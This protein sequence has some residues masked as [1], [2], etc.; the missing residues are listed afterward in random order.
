MAWYEPISQSYQESVVPNSSPVTSRKTTV[1]S[2]LRVAHLHGLGHGEGGG[3]GAGVVLG[4]AEV[5]VVVRANDD[6]LPRAL[7]PARDHADHVEAEPAVALQAHVDVGLDGRRDGAGLAGG[8]QLGA[9]RARDVHGGRRA[10]VRLGVE[11]AQRVRQAEVLTGGVE[12][13][14]RVRED[15]G[16]ARRGTRPASAGS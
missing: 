4:A 11:A 1:L 14:G 15:H 12:V 3:D 7:G 2:G 5:R 10:V 9:V 6:H 8:A 16:R 13:V